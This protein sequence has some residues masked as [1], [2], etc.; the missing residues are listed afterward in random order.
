MNDDE[1]ILS[2]APKLRKMPSALNSS[3]DL[4][5]DRSCALTKEK[6]T[7]YRQ[8]MDQIVKFYQAEEQE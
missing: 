7:Q 5:K 8:H 6:L 1:K 3:D 2:R 4:F